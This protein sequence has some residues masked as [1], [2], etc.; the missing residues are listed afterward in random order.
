MTDRTTIRLTGATSNYVDH[1]VRKEQFLRAHP[2]ATITNDRDASLHER[3]RGSLPACEEATSWDLGQLLDQLDV[4]VA[5]R[6]AR[7]R[8]P[9][10]V[11]TRT[12]FVWQAREID[13]DGMVEGSTLTQVEARIRQYERNQR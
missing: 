3:W 11:F 12:G 6:D 1:V 2:D 5:L 10:W 7:A 13:G 9:R 4:L 8:W